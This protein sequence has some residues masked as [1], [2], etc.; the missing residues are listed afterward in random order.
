MSRFRDIIKNILPH[1]YII[2]RR[3]NTFIEDY[4]KWRKSG[5]TVTF[6][7]NCRFK[8]F[9]SIDGFGCSGSSAVMDL[10]REYDNCTV[11][12]S[13]PLF[14]S[15]KENFV[16]LGELDIARH[17]GGLLYLELFMQDECYYH[18]SW[19]DAALKAFA[20][21]VFHSDIYNKFPDTHRLF[22]KFFD[23]IAY[24]Q[25][26]SKEGIINIHLNPYS[27]LTDMFSMRI[28]PQKDYHQLCRGLLYSLFNIIFKDAVTDILILDHIF[29][30]CGYNMDHFN[31]IL[32]GTKKIMVTRDIR[33]VYVHAKQK[34]IKWIAHENVE[35]F[36]KWEKRMYLNHDFDD[37]SYLSLHFEDLVSDYENQVQRIETYIGLA[38]EHHIHKRQIFNPSISSRNIFSWQLDTKYQKDCEEIMLSVP[39]LCIL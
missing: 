29:G 35:E 21:L 15:S 37:E 20:N 14:T 2:S 36:I 38:P 32:P 16:S 39:E 6:D 28:M 1:G 25:L 26:P 13:K 8:T 7:N 19:G 33:A 10:L 5:D 23:C 12:A 22:F 27:N 17:T 31:E 4:T 24:Q 11:W 3:R 34:D 30:D 18:D 9:V